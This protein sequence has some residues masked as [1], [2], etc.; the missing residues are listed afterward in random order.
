MGSFKLRLVAYFVLLSL[1]PLLAAAWGFNEVAGRSEVGNADARL[2]AALRVAVADYG[3]SVERDAAE[4]ARSLA[5]TPGV[6][7]ALATHNRAPLIRIAREVPNAA[8]F[9]NSKL[10]A[11]D[12]PTGIGAQRAARVVSQSRKELGRVVVSVPLDN[13]T[14]RRLVSKSGLRSTDLLVVARGDRIVVAPGILRNQ[15]WQGAPQPRYLDLGGSAYRAVSTDI[16][17]GGTTVKLV[18]L[19]PKVEIERAV[20]NLRQRFLL[21][22]FMALAVVAG[23]AYL[24]GRT[25]VRWLKELADAAGSVARGH[26]ERRVP[27]RGSDEFA[28]LGRTFNDMAAQLASRRAELEAERG[29][30]RD[31]IARFG[32]ALAAT[33]DPFAL[34][35]VIVESTVEAT[36]AAGGKLVVDGSEVARAGR[37]KKSGEPLTIVLSSDNGDDAQLLLWPTRDGFTDEERELA[38]WLGSQASIALENVRLHRMVE[39]QASTDGLTELSNRRQFEEVLDV[40]I[41]RAERFGGSLALIVADLDDFKQIN[42][43]YGHQAGD[44][45]LRAFAAVLRETARE[46]DLPARYG[47]EEFAILLPQTDASGARRLAERLR[48]T[49][50]SKPIST[51]AGGLVAVTASFGVAAYPDAPTA[52]ALFAAA[53]DALYKAK[54]AGKN[55]VVRAR[56]QSTTTNAARAAGH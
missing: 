24:L 40:E 1:L 29:R 31:A 26:F 20:S 13:A 30:V 21:F 33:H 46:V 53:D 43:R 36:G 52:A 12:P 3:E 45:V 5:R 37:P 9:S 8:F 56:K 49:L 44:E 27:V 38:H 2:N 11:G 19:T 50:S 51:N 34:L 41:Q 39:R 42:D 55:C 14:L 16:L 48:R 15:R 10:F 23:L 47:G 17:G 25:T 7:I 32:E 18:G 4:A 28:V 22:T 6:Q 54:A 35:P